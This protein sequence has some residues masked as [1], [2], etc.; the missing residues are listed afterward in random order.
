M[1]CSKCIFLD[2]SFHFLFFFFFFNES[3]H[4][5]QYWYPLTDYTISGGGGITRDKVAQI[6]LWFWPFCSIIGISIIVTIIYTSQKRICPSPLTQTHFHSNFPL[7]QWSW[8]RRE[9]SNFSNFH[10]IVKHLQFTLHIF[11]DIIF[12]HSRYLV[13][14]H[15]LAYSFLG[16]RE[17]WNLTTFFIKHEV[18]KNRIPK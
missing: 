7:S 15:L 14:I 17:Q 16:F 3:A 9:F 10:R 8:G 2:Y 18:R 11:G 5:V 4:A 12:G 6:F 13:N 1:Q